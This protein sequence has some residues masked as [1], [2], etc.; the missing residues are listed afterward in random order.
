MGY[1]LGAMLNTWIDLTGLPLGI[2]DLH[3][4][5]GLLPVIPLLMPSGLDP[6][7]VV[8]RKRAEQG[9]VPGLAAGRV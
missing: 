6:D 8:A 2:A 4:L 9:L 3:V 7:S 1:A 5:G